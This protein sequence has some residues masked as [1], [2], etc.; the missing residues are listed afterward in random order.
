MHGHEEAL[1]P[2]F[3]DR[4]CGGVNI[5]ETFSDLIPSLTINGSVSQSIS[6][7]LKGNHTQVLHEVQQ[8]LNNKCLETAPAYKSAEDYLGKQSWVNPAAQDQGGQ[9]LYL[10]WNCNIFPLVQGVLQFIHTYV[11]KCPW[12]GQACLYYQT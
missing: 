7:K 6:I 10:S 2:S 11:Y 12:G 3:C 9:S 1:L 5:L 4:G 8:W